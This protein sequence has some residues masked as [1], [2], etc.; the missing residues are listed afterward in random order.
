MWVGGYYTSCLFGCY[1][2][3]SQSED[4]RVEAKR[5]SDIQAKLISPPLFKQPFSTFAPPHTTPR[6]PLLLATWLAVLVPSLQCALHFHKSPGSWSSCSR[7]N[8]VESRNALETDSVDLDVSK[9]DTVSKRQCVASLVP[10]C[11]SRC[12]FP[13]CVL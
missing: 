7:N 11:V 3:L 2:R 13:P 10:W 9:V 12:M 4:S 8:N 6:L 5:E 1:T